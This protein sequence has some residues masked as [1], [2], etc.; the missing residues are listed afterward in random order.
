MIVGLWSALAFCSFNIT[1]HFFYIAEIKFRTW[2]F[3][4]P[5]PFWRKIISYHIYKYIKHFKLFVSN[6]TN[7]SYNNGIYKHRICY[8]YHIKFKITS[9]IWNSNQYNCYKTT[10][11]LLLLAR[12]QVKLYLQFI[13]GQY[14]NEILVKC[15]IWYDFSLWKHAQR[16]SEDIVQGRKSRY[17]TFVAYRKQKYYNLDETCQYF[18]LGPNVPLHSAAL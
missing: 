10:Y 2:V 6:F 12:N 3:M 1:I 8:Q 15:N 14:N 4:M 18:E 9:I 13:H 11:P 16:P 17:S 5:I 7:T